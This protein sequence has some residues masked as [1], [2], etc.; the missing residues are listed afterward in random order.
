MD[1]KL[2]KNVISSDI[3]LTSMDQ[4]KKVK[5]AKIDNQDNYINKQDSNKSYYLKLQ[6]EWDYLHKYL[7][8]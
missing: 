1:Y 2:N 5:N 6:H 7:H 8:H 4:A 3:F